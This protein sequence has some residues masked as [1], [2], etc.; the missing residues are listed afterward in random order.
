MLK[1]EINPLNLKADD[2]DIEDIAHSLS[3]LCRF[4]GRVTEFYSVA[5]HCVHV[6]SFCKNKLWGLLHDAS[7]AYLGD[8]IRPIKMSHDFLIYRIYEAKAMETIAKKF[9]L[10]L[11]IPG[12]VL[13]YDEIVIAT[14]IR[15]L[16]PWL[17]SEYYPLGFKI[18][19]MAPKVAE[20]AFLT[21]YRSLV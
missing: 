6:S 16:A 9:R 13:K 7:E 10:K 2:I 14:E 15:D 17:K 18:K 5:E 1:K 4:N 3:N 11:P 8:M 12:D 20:K 21:A 19:P